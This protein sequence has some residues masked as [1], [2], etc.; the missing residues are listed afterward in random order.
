MYKIDDSD[1][2]IIEVLKYNSKLSTIAIAKKTG[3]PPAT[4]NRR[5]K[6]MLQFGV[7]KNFSVILDYEKI[8]LA[9]SAYILVRSTPGAY[10]YDI[11]NT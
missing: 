11:S 9:T 3:I 6:K 10:D 5:I 7:I 1:K 2:S 4:V 8:G